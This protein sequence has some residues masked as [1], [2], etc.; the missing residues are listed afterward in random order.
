MS[1]PP[2]I[3]YPPEPTQAQ[4]DYLVTSVHQW[5][6]SNG[7]VVRSQSEPKDQ[8][9]TTAPV[10]LYPS[11]F[12]RACFEEAR[13]IQCA[14]NELYAKIASDEPWLGKIVDE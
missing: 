12:P 13:A 5:S 11:L 14:Y 10:T 9:A 2:A 4:E 1:A 8:N 3:A 7:L 6:L